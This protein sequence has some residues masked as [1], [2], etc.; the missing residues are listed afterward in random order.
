MVVLYYIIL[1]KFQ[2]SE[3]TQIENACKENSL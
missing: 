3:Y 1:E 2:A